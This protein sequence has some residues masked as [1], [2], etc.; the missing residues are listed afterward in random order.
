V[1]IAAGAAALT[2][3]HWIFVVAVQPVAVAPVA[4][5]VLCLASLCIGP[6]VWSRFSIRPGL[7]LIAAGYCGLLALV[8]FGAD[9]GL[10][11]LHGAQRARAHVAEALGGLELWHVLGCSGIGVCVGGAAHGW[12]IGRRRRWASHVIHMKAL[13]PVLASAQALLLA[14]APVFAAESPPISEAATE[15]AFQTFLATLR[16]AA[17]NKDAKT[18]HAA[19]AGD[20]Y[21][22]RDFGGGYDPA[23]PPVQNFSLIFEFDSAKLRP[24]YQ[25]HGWKELRKALAAH[26]FERKRDG[27]MCLP[28]GAQDRRPVPH[29]QMCFRR[30]APAAWG[31]AGYIHGGD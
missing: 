17:A 22:K 24:E 6:V 15:P 14:A 21:V 11:A 19:L 13:A 5:F 31:I 7:W 1:A 10:D 25:D 12:V 16:Q 20:F 8:C 9:G 26:T 29:A 23:A 2:V 27:Q 30:T 28:H 4:G 18:V 3:V